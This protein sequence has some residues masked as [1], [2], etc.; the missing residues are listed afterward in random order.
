MIVVVTEVPKL[1][2]DVCQNGEAGSAM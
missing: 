1:L 2:V